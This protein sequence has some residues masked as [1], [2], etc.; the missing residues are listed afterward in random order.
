LNDLI[1]DTFVFHGASLRLAVYA[2]DKAV[3]VPQLYCIRIIRTDERAVRYEVVVVADR[4]R[5]ARPPFPNLPKKIL[6]K[7]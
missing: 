5:T 7:R 1:L 2:K 6:G 3:T 4:A